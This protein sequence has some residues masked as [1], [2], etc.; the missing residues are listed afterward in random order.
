LQSPFGAAATRAGLQF[1]GGKQGL[2]S[3]GM[4]D[5]RHLIRRVAPIFFSRL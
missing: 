4:T 5:I 1:L 2:I 3:N